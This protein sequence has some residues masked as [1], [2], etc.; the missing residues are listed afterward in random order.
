VNLGFRPLA[1][2]DLR[3]VHEWLQR[4]H[5]RRWWGEDTAY[6]DVVAH[7]LPAIE[8]ADPTDLF[9]IVLDGRAVGMIEM[10]LVAD[11]PDYDALV[12][13]GRGV[14]G[15]D[16][17]IGEEEL[18][19]RGLG[20]EVLRRFVREV[21]FGNAATTAC[22]AGVDVENA[23]SLRAFA[24]AGFRAVHDYEEEGRPHRLLRIERGG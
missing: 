8:G 23:A 1:A 16:L 11:H 9:L 20:T 3:A 18:T 19:A 17:F 13:V 22:I 10:Y 12:Q 2:S 4:P 7:Y 6:E 21:V 15:V 14:A 24:K 5:V